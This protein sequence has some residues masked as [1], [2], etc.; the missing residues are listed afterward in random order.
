MK[1]IPPAIL[2]AVMSLLLCYAC[3]LFVKETDEFDLDDTVRIAIGQKLYENERLWLRLDKITLDSRCPAGMAS[4]PPGHVEGQF[5]AGGW[6]DTETLAFRTDSVN[7]ISFMVPFEGG[8]GGGNYFILHIIDVNPVKSDSVTAIPSKDYRIDFV[9]ESGMVARKPNIY[10]YPEK[11]LKLDVSLFFPQGGEVIVSDPQYPADWLDIRVRP[12]GRIGRK[13]DY[14]FYEAAI[15]DLWQY[16]EGWVVKQ[17]ILP[18]FF[19]SNL[20]A[21][22]FNENEIRDFMDYWIPLLNTAPYYAVYPQHTASVNYAVKLRI[23]ERPDAMLRLFYVIDEAQDK[24]TLPEP[25]IPEFER[26]G[27]SVTEWG[28]VLGVS[29]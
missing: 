13:Y 15:P 26:N 28:V 24:F 21:Y 6:G 23:S 17:D 4:D 29:E 25:E 18:L 20:E 22:G 19:R 27:F 14:L 8:I 9:L 3:N 5:T 1:R 10:L 2:I 7:S 16:S 11:S 12:D